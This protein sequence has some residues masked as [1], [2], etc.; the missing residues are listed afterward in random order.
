[1]YYF[2][3]IEQMQSEVAETNYKKYYQ[4]HALSHDVEFITFLC[5]L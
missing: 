5:C 3:H 2:R 4:S 1:M